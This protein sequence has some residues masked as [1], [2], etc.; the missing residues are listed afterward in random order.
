MTMQTLDIFFALRLPPPRSGFARRAPWT[1]ARARN[2]AR[3]S[4]RRWPISSSQA[5]IADMATAIDSAALLPTAR[6]GCAT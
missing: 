6:P 3:C 5:A 4:A 1:G 2:G